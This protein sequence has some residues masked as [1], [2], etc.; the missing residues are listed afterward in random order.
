[1]HSQR[2]IHRAISRLAVAGLLVAPLFGCAGADSGAVDEP[3]PTPAPGHQLVGEFLLHAQPSQRKLTIRRITP[4]LRDALAQPGF[5]PQALFDANVA[6]DGTPGSGAASSVELITTNVT[7]TYGTGAGGNCTA[8][9]Q[10]CADVTLNSFWPSTLNFTYAQVVSIS[11]A[12]GKATTTHSGVNSDFPGSTKLDRTLGL[13]IHESANVTT[14]GSHPTGTSTFTP[15]K[16]GVVTSYATYGAASGAKATWIFANPDDADTYVRLRVMAATT[17]ANYTLNRSAALSSSTFLDA[18][19]IRAGEA[20]PPIFDSANTQQSQP[21]NLNAYY[22][23]KLPF[24]F[25][26]YA[27]PYAANAHLNFSKSGVVTFSSG[28][29]VT[30]AIP[31]N[32]G[33]TDNG[34]LTLPST[35]AAR[36]GFYIWWDNLVAS[37]SGAGICAKQWGT[38]P[39]RHIALGWN[40]IAAN[41]NGGK[42]PYYK[43]SAVLNESTE[44][45][46][47]Y[48]A[49]LA[50][51]TGT[52]T[53]SATVG[54]ENASASVAAVNSINSTSAFP[55]ASGTVRWVLQP[56]A[57]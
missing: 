2:T 9:N 34:T 17:Y 53:F 39:N 13:W 3:D 5:T 48:Y 23:A 18:C 47:L 1:M 24:Q 54:A 46:W 40:R 22:Y 57:L 15:G 31:P 6:N 8:T 28:A 33:S 52:K 4:Q 45:I 32:N 35:N 49:P 36:P 56:M 38:A 55:G 51:G 27:S 37:G 41:G 50:T 19:T 43:M 16:Q 29:A 21:L 25:T 30:P 14:P 42:G 11:D 44:E 12:T 26:Y 20:R 10:F 7:D